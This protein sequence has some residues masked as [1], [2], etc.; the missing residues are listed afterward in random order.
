MRNTTVQL[1]DG[2]LVG[3]L[4]QPKSSRRLIVMCHGYQSSGASPTIVA[5]AEMLNQ[6]GYTTFL[7]TF[8]P[9]KGSTDVEQQ[10]G[11]LDAI[12]KYFESFDEVILFGNSFGALSASIA[13]LVNPR[14]NG[15]ITVSGFFGRR[16]LGP[17]Y[18]RSYFMF[19]T[20]GL[21]HP[22]YR[23]ILRYTKRM[24]RPE[25]IKVPVLVIHSKA[26]IDVLVAQSEWFFSRLSTTKQLLTLDTANHGISLDADRRTVVK[27][28]D[29]WLSSATFQRQ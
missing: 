16:Q 18:R 21:L 23:R 15:L 17:K 29:T 14:V 11:D 20:L 4:T 9:S 5:L 1:R 8:S 27:A 10:V 6:K 22:N 26:D 28:I 13:A 2:A 12:I 19:E 25:Q 3:E 24:L 7:F